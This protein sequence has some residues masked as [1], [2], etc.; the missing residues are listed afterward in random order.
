MVV[1]WTITIP[2]AGLVGALTWALG[3][4][5]AGVTGPLVM[6]GLLAGFGAWMWM[7]SQ[8]DPVTSNNVND[9][10]EPARTPTP[11]HAS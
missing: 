6:V 2:A 8:R 1:A 10:W 7:R 11:V 3:H 9:A 5:L 4:R